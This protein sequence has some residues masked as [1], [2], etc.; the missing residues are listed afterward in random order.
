MTLI[1]V[2]I[3]PDDQK[4]IKE[5]T[6]FDGLNLSAFVRAKVRERYSEFQRRRKE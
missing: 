1:S 5:L 2:N 6:E 3:N 4:K